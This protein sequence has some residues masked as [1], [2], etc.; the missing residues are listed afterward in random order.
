MEN[1]I[2][3]RYMG[4]KNYATFRV[5]HDTLSVIDYGEKVS[6]EDVRKIALQNVLLRHDMHDNTRVEESARMI[7]NLVDFED[8]AETINTDIKNIR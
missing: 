1:D 6:A 8:I 4:W 3:K 5:F 7:M 2:T